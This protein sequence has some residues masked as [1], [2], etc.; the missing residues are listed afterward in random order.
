[1]RRRLEMPTE[2]DTLD[3]REITC[4]YCGYV[5]GDSW[6]VNQGEMEWEEDID[7]GRCGKTFLAFKQVTVTY[8][9]QTLTVTI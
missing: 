3:T 9:T 2:F 6:E 4:P 7:C 1:M 5:F 8:S